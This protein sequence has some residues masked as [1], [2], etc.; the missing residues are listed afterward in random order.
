MAAIAR[1]AHEQSNEYPSDKKEFY[2]QCR[3][4]KR[5]AFRRRPFM[6]CRYHCD[7]YWSCVCHFKY[8]NMVCPECEQEVC[9]CDGRY[10]KYKI[11]DLSKDINKIP[12]DNHF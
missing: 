8:G 12:T 9:D 2:I 10:I 6:E 1:Q 3:H 11:L 4:C 7:M 5:E